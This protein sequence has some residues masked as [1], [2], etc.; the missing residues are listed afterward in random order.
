MEIP[1]SQIKADSLNMI[2]ALDNE[3]MLDTNID[4]L[5][6]GIVSGGRTTATESQIAQA[7]SNIIGLLNNKIN[8]WGDKRFRFEWWKGYQENFSKADKKSV[9]LVSNFEIK[10]FEL[11]KD[12]FFTK[13]IPHIIL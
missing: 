13:Q 10:S 7:N 3:A 2:Q 4:T 6:Q 9:V 1:R 11:G 5:Q 12:D 8:A